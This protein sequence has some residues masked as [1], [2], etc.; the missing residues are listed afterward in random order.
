[1]ELKSATIRGGED[2]EVR[3]AGRSIAPGLG[4]GRAWV[5]GDVLKASGAPQVISPDQIDGELLRLRHALLREA[6]CEAARGWRHDRNPRP[7]AGNFTA[8]EARR[9]VLR[10]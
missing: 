3:L 9:F 7:G 2:L 5:V 1:M 4:L 10:R 6:E 8:P